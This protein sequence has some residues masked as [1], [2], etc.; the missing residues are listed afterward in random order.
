MGPASR[1]VPISTT[2]PPVGGLQLDV[3]KIQICS[4]IASE[5]PVLSRLADQLR[6]EELITPAAQSTVKF[7]DGRSPYE[8]ADIMMSPAIERIRNDPGRYAPALVRALTS[9]G[10]GS[11]TTVS[12]LTTAGKLQQIKCRE[13]GTVE[14]CRLVI[15]SLI[16]SALVSR[17]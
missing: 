8:K 6:C 12:C 1:S 16:C 11:V 10:L 14:Q 4:S 9:V 13:R 2:L 5:P 3:I 17:K 15:L 7:I